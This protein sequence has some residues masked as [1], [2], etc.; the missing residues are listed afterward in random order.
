[1][2]F[3]LIIC[4]LPFMYL[5]IILVSPFSRRDSSSFRSSAI[6]SLYLIVRS[7]EKRMSLKSGE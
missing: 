6:C 2:F 1:M 4:G 3:E 7:D 5:I